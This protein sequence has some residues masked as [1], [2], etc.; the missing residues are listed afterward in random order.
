MNATKQ[1]ECGN[2]ST[3][4][5]N[6]QDARI[7]CIPSVKVVYVCEDCDESH[8]KEEDAERCCDND[9]CF[10]GHRR[11]SHGED[12]CDVFLSSTMGECPCVKFEV[13]A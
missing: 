4:Y 9:E 1:W 8:D 13:T 10:C 12:G 7:C 6:E 5:E 3:T 2:C 11:S